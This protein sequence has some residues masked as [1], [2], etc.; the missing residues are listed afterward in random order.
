M[1]RCSAC[2][3]TDDKDG[4][5]RHM[6]WCPILDVDEDRMDGDETQFDTT[7]P[8]QVPYDFTTNPETRD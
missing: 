8:F 2:R 6:S 1:N 7:D 5:D 4:R 3:R